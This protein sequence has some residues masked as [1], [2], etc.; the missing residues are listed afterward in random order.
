M[1][2]PDE[3]MEAYCI[4]LIREDERE[5]CAKIASARGAVWR[6]KGSLVL[7]GECEDI[8]RAIRNRLTVTR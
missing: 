1:K 7:E 4:R 3:T 5:Q 2:R 6:L 8:A